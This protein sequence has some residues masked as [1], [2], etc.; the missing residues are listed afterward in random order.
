MDS[1]VIKHNNTEI[2]LFS[3]FFLVKATLVKVSRYTNIICDKYLQKV[4]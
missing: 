3:H 2:C 1:T 4:Y